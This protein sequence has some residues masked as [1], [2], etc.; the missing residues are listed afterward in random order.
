MNKFSR[1]NEFIIKKDYAIIFVYYKDQKSKC[2]VDK[3]DCEFLINFGK[4][5]IDNTGYVKNSHKSQKIH[6]LIMKNP[7]NLHIDHINGDKL[8]NRKCNLRV[9]TVSENRQ[10]QLV[11]YKNN[12]SG[13]IG[14]YFATSHRGTKWEKYYW[15]VDISCSNVGNIK[16]TYQLHEKDEAI[17]F[18]KYVRAYILPYSKEA[19][20]ISCIPDDVKRY[21]DERI[22]A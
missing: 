21:V 17:L 12:K 11:N 13:Q 2:L 16:K 8:D 7:I 5:Y 1:R 6:R 19:R 10:N 14:V 18:A 9:A 22:S 20:E 3:E 15:K 4:W